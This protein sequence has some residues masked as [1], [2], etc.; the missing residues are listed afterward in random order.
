MRHT[1]KHSVRARSS[2]HAFTLIEL[3]VVIAII[4]ILAAMLLPALANAKERAKR[5]NCVSNL[6]QIGIAAALYCHDYSDEFPGLKVVT[7]NGT[8]YESQFVWVGKKG[9][10]SPYS[11]ID[12][13]LRALN[14][15]LGKFGA[16]SQVE[17]AHCPSDT[18]ATVGTYN[19]FGSSYAHNVHPD[20]ALQ[21]LGVGNSRACKMTNIRN[22][23]KMVVIAEEGAY[24]PSWNPEEIKSQFFIH[25]KKG[26]YRWNIAFADAHAD[27]VRLE[28]KLG[29][30]IMS[31]RDYTYDRT[32]P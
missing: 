26:D 16:T 13:T 4:A 23:S 11:S 3:L 21:T 14:P 29:I 22:P 24:F 1:Q 5:I 10:V 17:V 18:A 30:R 32:K 20:A 2:R 7:T 25:S 31:G 8:T 15:Y 27:F 9:N 19:Y 6:K 12:A 28:Y